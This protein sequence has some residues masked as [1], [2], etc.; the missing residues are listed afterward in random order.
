MRFALLL[1]PALLHAEVRTMTLAEAIDT[2]LRQ[3]ADIVIARLE[4]QKAAEQV[5][6]ARDPFTPRVIAGS[7]LA[8]TW[9]FPMSIEGSAPSVVQARV[10][11]SL[12]NKPRSYEV[13]AARENV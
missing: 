7:G 11:Q 12:Y 4:E 2:A 8:K 1:L 3:N 10:I 13:A 9:G 6:I 5:R